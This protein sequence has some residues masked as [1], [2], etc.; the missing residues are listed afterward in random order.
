ML[1]PL[2]YERLCLD[3]NRLLLPVTGSGVPVTGLCIDKMRRR[4]HDGRRGWEPQLRSAPL[5]LALLL[6]ARK[7]SVIRSLEQRRGL[8]VSASVRLR[9]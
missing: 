9:G 6:L 1:Y 4:V 3:D 5:A 7:G 2:S 8:Y